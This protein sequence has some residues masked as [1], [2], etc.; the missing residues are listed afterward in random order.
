[1]TA[2]WNNILAAIR[3]QVTTE[4]FRTY[5]QPIQHGRIEGSEF[6]VEVGD[7]FFGDWIRQHYSD[8]LEAAITEVA[9]HRYTVRIQTV[10]AAQSPDPVEVSEP[11]PVTQKT[12]N[13]PS[14]SDGFP[15]NPRYSFDT[16]VV[17]PGNELA[18]AASI[19]VAQEP[20]ITFN[21]LFIYGGTGL[22]K[23]HL[24]H[25]I[26][27]RITQN[28]PTTRI[29]YISAEEFTNQVIKSIQ[30]KQMDAL[31]KRYRRNCDILLM[32]DVHVL[33]GKEA[34]QEEFFHTFNAL[35]GAQKQIILTSDRPPQEISRLEE[36]LRSRFH[37]GLITDIHPPQFETRV[38]ILQSKAEQLKI[39]LPSEVAYY[40]ARN[41]QANVRELEGA[42]TRLSAYASL[43]HCTLT[44]ELAHNALRG[45]FES[46]G[47]SLSI[48]RVIGTVAQHFGVD[49]AEICGKK[50]HRAIARPRSIAMYLCRK[51]VQASFPEIGRNFGGKDHTTV[52]AACRKIDAALDSDQGVKTDIELLERKISQ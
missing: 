24:L 21:P 17:G 26:A 11:T 19:A 12:H 5:F 36:R 14:L 4:N 39:K 20:A 45:L 28:D 22:G 40:L 34:T 13:R 44:L 10:D 41:V 46:R 25:S 3:T 38:A 32:D 27:R 31:R 7:S 42:L 33:A 23:T 15:L 49:K 18:H 9:G 29:T 43:N 37:W 50:R 52:M 2:L 30:R 1:M 16:F 6:I 35:H 8:L 48:G 47:P 51:H